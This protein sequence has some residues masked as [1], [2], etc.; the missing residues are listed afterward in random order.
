MQANKLTKSQN[1]NCMN[2]RMTKW[3]PDLA[4]PIA[5]TIAMAITITIAITVEWVLTYTETKNSNQLP[6]CQW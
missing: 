2:E 1:Q 5:I 6:Q 3:V 4:L